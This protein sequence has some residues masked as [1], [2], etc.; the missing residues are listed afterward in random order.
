MRITIFTSNN[1]DMT[2]T[3]VADITSKHR[4]YNYPHNA[5]IGSILTGQPGNTKPLVSSQSTL[6]PCT[7]LAAI[8]DE[9]IALALQS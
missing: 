7:A 5:F 6:A 9:I 8:Y 1:T 2:P 3:R 4:S